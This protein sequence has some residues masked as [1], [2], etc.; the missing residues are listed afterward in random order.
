MNVHVNEVS[1]YI[2][3]L[4]SLAVKA[5]YEGE[6]LRLKEAES[7]AY[8]TSSEYLLEVGYSLIKFWNNVGGSMPDHSEIVA[9]K[10]LD[11]IKKVWPDF[12]LPR[13]DQN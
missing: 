10:C 2:N 12:V 9:R 4:S 5:G 8:S 6:A 7:A 13:L 3:E 1:S 11:E